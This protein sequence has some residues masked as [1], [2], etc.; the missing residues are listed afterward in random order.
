MKKS[1]I[2][3]GLLAVTVLSTPMAVS[4]AK[5]YQSY[6]ELYRLYIV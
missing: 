2:I 6:T 4:A 1:W 3:A 5:G